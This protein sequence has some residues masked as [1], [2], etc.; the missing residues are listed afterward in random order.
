MCYNLLITVYSN[1][2]AEVED[3]LSVSTGSDFDGDLS[4]IIPT[5]I[6]T[7]I[8]MNTKTNCIGLQYTQL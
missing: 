2:E 3:L 1:K 4:F 5:I 6:K 7:K 8:K